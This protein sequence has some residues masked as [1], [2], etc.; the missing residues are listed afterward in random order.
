MRTRLAA[1]LLTLGAA[2]PAA[3]QTAYSSSAAFFAALSGASV[4]EGYESY[5]TNTLFPAGSSA[6]GITYTAFPAG[7]LAGRVDDLYNRIGDRSLAADRDNDPATEDFFLAGESFT[8]SFVQPIYAIGIYFNIQQS[9]DN[10]VFISTPVGSASSGGATYDQST[11][12]FVGL[13]S[14]TAFSTATI[15][16]LANA[17]SGYNVDDLT[18][19]V[20]AVPEPS[21]V[22]LLAGGLAALGG[23][24][25]RR[26]TR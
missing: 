5:A 15:G 14:P 2:T 9:P 19:A 12:Y 26:A 16:A 25:R 13:I 3:A 8:V 23:L 7:V 1:L 21:T 11:L 22:L 24:V 10:S 4:T 17:G 6:N 20:S 18:F